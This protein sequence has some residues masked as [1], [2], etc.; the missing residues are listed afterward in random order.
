VARRD[1]AAG[2][3]EYSEA[4]RLGSTS[5]FLHLKLGDL[6]SAK[7]D[8]AGARDHY[9]KFIQNDSTSGEARRV[10]QW[11]SRSLPRR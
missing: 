7:G 3:A 1:T 11:L 2:L 10:R 4:V 6:T 9:R 8:L 5:H